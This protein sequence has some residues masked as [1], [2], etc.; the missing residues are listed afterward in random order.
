MTDRE[1]LRRLARVHAA[2]KDARG[3]RPENLP[4]RP[5]KTVGQ[6]GVEQDWSGGRSQDQLMN[7]A[8]SVI[9]SIMGLRDRAVTFLRANGRDPT[10]VEDFVD[11]DKNVAIVHDLANK[12]KHGKL[13]RPRSASSPEIRSL[14]RALQL[15]AEP[16]S[17]AS[18]T[19]KMTGEVTIVGHGD[20]GLVGEIVDESGVK[21]GAFEQ[22]IE[23]AI[24]SWEEFL[25]R[26]GI[27][28]DEKPPRDAQPSLD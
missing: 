4:G 7:D 18:F 3:L 16:G 9:N 22:V 26:I 19:M 1:L 23:S 14:T 28:L 2:L 27:S 15:R 20:V 24:S 5:I 12:D 25:A 17:V 11:G 21:L 8:L 10:I 6:I 13:D